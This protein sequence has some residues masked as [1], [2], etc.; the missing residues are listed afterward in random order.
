MEAQNEGN[1]SQVMHTRSR[2]PENRVS[3]QPPLKRRRHSRWCD[4]VEQRSLAN[5]TEENAH[6]V[7]QRQKQI[8]Y[9]KNTIAYDRFNAVCPR[10]SRKR[11]DPMTP[12]AR[13]NCSKRSFAGQITSWKKLVYAFVAE[14]D[15]QQ[16]TDS[17]E[18]NNPSLMGMD[19]A[20]TDVSRKA[21]DDIEVKV[22]AKNA[23]PDTEIVD[24]PPALPDWDE[25]C[26]LSD[27]DDIELDDYGNVV[28]KTETLPSIEHSS[29]ERTKS[30]ESPSS[31]F[32]AF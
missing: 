30:D 11:G 29:S 2:S 18:Q 20:A 32:D 1:N 14:L 7:A 31:I 27:F 25:E 24:K 19:D 15:A 16:K 22:E 13:Q 12:L 9:G 6:R 23:A 21:S 4:I 10:Q 5:G 3:N 28:E 17:G 8:D 26:E